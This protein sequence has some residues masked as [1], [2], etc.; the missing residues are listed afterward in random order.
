[1]KDPVMPVEP[2][3]SVVAMIKAVL[4]MLSVSW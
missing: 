1:M 2:R 3:T 4:E